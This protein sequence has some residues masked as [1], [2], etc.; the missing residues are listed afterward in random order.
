MKNIA[1]ATSC[2]PFSSCYQ[3]CRV[4]CPIIRYSANYGAL[5]WHVKH[6]GEQN[7]SLIEFSTNCEY[8]LIFIDNVNNKTK[9]YT[10]LRPPS[11]G[12]NRKYVYNSY[13]YI[14]IYR[15]HLYDGIMYWVCVVNIKSSSVWN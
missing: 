6:R 14:Y 2:S 8:S 13:I 5:S 9:H 4:Y 1:I 15:K 3:T 11:C 10:Y 7:V 12:I